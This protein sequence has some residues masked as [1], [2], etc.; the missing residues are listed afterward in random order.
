MAEYLEPE[1]CDD[2]LEGSDEDDEEVE[3]ANN[4]NE[5]LDL[6]E[7]EDVGVG[8]TSAVDNPIFLEM[9]Q[10]LEDSDE[11][12]DEEG[13]LAKEEKKKADDLARMDKMAKMLNM[14][15]PGID[16]RSTKILK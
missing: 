12:E 8:T 3:Q 4:Y 15:A 9:L 2:L 16:L 13:R 7:L 14:V 10:P 1:D 6:N 11:E 5:L